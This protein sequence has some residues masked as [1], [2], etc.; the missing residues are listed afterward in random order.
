M[1]VYRRY[2]I[3]HLPQGDLAGFGAAWLGWDAAAATV[4]PRPEI[5]R[6]S[7]KAQDVTETPRRY[8]FHGTLKPPFRLAEG[9]RPRALPEVAE[10]F[11]AQLPAVVC[12]GLV[13]RRLG[14][15]LALVPEGA[16]PGLADLAAALVEG[17]DNFRAPPGEAELARRRANGLTA[18]Q[19][20][21]LL[22]WGYPYVME[23]FRF[24]LTLTGPVAPQHADAV[25]AALARA[26][27]PLLPR[28]F[29]VEHVALMGEDD[30]GFFHLIE[31]FPLGG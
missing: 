16:V 18:R 8:G 13:L 29:R 26:F 5:G 28:P 25:E 24:H 10:T 23:E 4:P 6:L 14:R 20:A 15:F 21:L 11:A 30:D 19:E 3:Y 27:G 22:R 12:D 17:L 7:V 1:R 9:T 2:A 31:R